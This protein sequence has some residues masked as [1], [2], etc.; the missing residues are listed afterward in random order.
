MRLVDPA[1]L[2]LAANRDPEFRLAARYWNATLSLE[3]PARALRVEV[4][5]GEV[6]RCGE[7][8]SGQPA[9]ITVVASGEG[10]ARFLAPVPPPFYQDLLGGCVQHHGFQVSGDLL[11]LSAY[12]QA[13]QRLFALMRILGHHGS[14]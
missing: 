5:E 14:V 2:Q 1:R 13:T 12:Y 4:A 6:V 11:S 8:G 3:S 7:G 9:T 10:W